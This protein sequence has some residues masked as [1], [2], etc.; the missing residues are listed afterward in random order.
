MQDQIFLLAVA[1]AVPG[2]KA[3]SAD[4]HA[5][6]YLVAVVA[7]AE[8][9]ICLLLRINVAGSMVL[10]IAHKAARLLQYWMVGWIE[11]CT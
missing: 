9:F 10:R 1:V 6:A 7:L 4:T 8:P 11:A 3:A 5:H 2:N